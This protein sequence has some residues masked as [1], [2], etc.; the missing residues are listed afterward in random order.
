[1][2]PRFF[3][4]LAR[5]ALWITLGVCTGP[6]LFRSLRE[7]TFRMPKPG[8]GSAPTGASTSSPRV[9]SGGSMEKL[10]ERGSKRSPPTLSEATCGPAQP[11]ALSRYDLEGRRNLRVPVPEALAQEQRLALPPA[12]R[13]PVA[14]PRLSATEFH[15][16]WRARTLLPGAGAHPF[17]PPGGRAES[18]ESRFR[19]GDSDLRRRHRP[20][21]R[22]GRGSR[23][24][25]ARQPVRSPPGR[26]WK[27][28]GSGGT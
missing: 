28:L 12:G 3:R 21:G 14:Q 23:L 2:K 18:P 13:I 17:P 9:L 19:E 27:L 24:H 10:P 26:R 8:F 6:G 20:G 22:T 16:R 1:M 7:K 25:P 4:L 15:R 11:T 5:T